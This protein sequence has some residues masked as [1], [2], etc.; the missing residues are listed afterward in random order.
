MT[1]TEKVRLK[2]LDDKADYSLWKIRLEAV[3]SVKGCESAL[4]SDGPPEGVLTDQF[5]QH[6]K[7]A[8]GIIVT[9]LNDSALR[10]VRSVIGKPN[11]MLEKLNA[12]FDSRTTSS[13]ITRMVE[14][15]S[16][17]YRGVRSDISKHIDKMAS[18]LE[19]LRAMNAII[20]DPLAVGILLAS[21]D[22]EELGP[23]VAAI[24]TLS[25]ESVKWDGVAERLIEESRSIR[26]SGHVQA[27]VA[28]SHRPRENCDYCHRPG[29]P[30]SRCWIN[31]DN[32]NNRLKALKNAGNKSHEKTDK[33]GSGKKSRRG[34]EVAAMARTSNARRSS[35]SMMIDSGTSSHITPFEH[36]VSNLEECDVTITLGDD[37]TVPSVTQGTRRVQWQGEDGP[38]N[39]N[40]SNTLVAPDVSLSLLSVPALVEKGLA[41]LFVPT[42]AFIININDGNTIIGTASQGTDKLFYISDHADAYPD[43]QDDGVETVRTFMAV[44]EPYVPAQVPKSSSSSDEAERAA[45]SDVDV[46]SHGGESE[47]TTLSD[48]DVQ[49]DTPTVTFGTSNNETTS[50]TNVSLDKN[51]ARPDSH[52]TASVVATWHR[53][54]GHGLSKTA[55]AN[56]VRAG[57]LPTKVETAAP[58][59]DPCVKGK[60]RESFKGSLTKRTTVGHLH[61]DTKGKIPKTSVN[62]Y[63]HFVTVVDEYSRFVFTHPI[64]SKGEASGVVL[65]YVRWFE[66]QSG[67]PV[68]SFHTDNGREYT[69]AI[70]ALTNMGVDTSTTTAYTAAS[71]GLAER[72]HGVLMS[73]ARAVLLQAK[74][75]Q[76]YWDYA[77][78]HVTTSK[79][80]LPHSTTKE[81]PYVRLLGQQSPDLHH[82]RPFGC[83]ILYRP[84]MDRLPTFSPRL[85]EGICL[86][87]DGGGVYRVLSMKGIV[88]TKHVR[89]LENDFPGLRSLLKNK[90]RSDQEEE[91]QTSEVDISLSDSATEDDGDGSPLDDPADPITYVPART[92]TFGNTDDEDSDSSK[93]KENSS[94]EADDVPDDDEYH[95]DGDD[96]DDE[97]DEDLPSR[98]TVRNLRNIPRVQYTYTA[99]PSCISTSDEP[100]VSEALKSPE[101]SEW[102][103]AITEEFMNLLKLKTWSEESHP[104]GAKAIPSGIVLKLK[105]DADGKPCRFKARLVA[106]G[107]LQD[108]M[109]DFGEL[110]APVACIEVVRILLAVAY[111]KGWEVHHVDIKG[112]FLYA[113]LKETRPTYIRLPKLKFIP[114]ANGLIVRLHKSLYG[115]RQAPKL[116][117]Q[118]LA[119]TLLKIN[120][121]RSRSTDCLFIGPDP[122]RPVYLLVYVDDIMVVGDARNVQTV[123]ALLASMFTTTDLGLCTHFLGIKLERRPFGLFLTQRPYIEKIINLAGMQNASA[124]DAPLPL[125]HPLYQVMEKRSESERTAIEHVPYRQV[126]GSLLFLST[127]TRPDLATSVSMLGKFQAEPT[128]RHWKMMKSVVRYLIGTKD[129][130]LLFPHGQSHPRLISW[131]DAD[132]A[133]DLTR[134]RSRSGYVLKIGTAPVVW[135][136]RLQENTAMSTSESEFNSLSAAVREIVWVRAVLKDLDTLQSGP[137]VLYQDNLGAICWTS[138]IQGLRNVKHVGMRYHFVREEV[139]KKTVT[140]QYCESA[141]NHADSLTKVLIGADFLTHRTYLGCTH[142]A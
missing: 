5:E 33:D 1:D 44:T 9:A 101:R 8:S 16:L 65:R 79:N 81:I 132:W 121:R 61:A 95:D 35:D 66:R 17:R 69:K 100:S 32:P 91:A 136:S 56:Q 78:A 21:I 38:V 113:R 135:A 96:G 75:P 51:T 52:K 70:S 87:H 76:S 108:D 88:R 98:H 92:S 82:V 31:P 63:S 116:W 110:Y 111:A 129:F 123:K 139:E 22:V 10:V 125:S 102:I 49:P 137:T 36:K 25:E 41:V 4:T 127:R 58:D 128:I 20:D 62:G 74:L 80:M 13:K 126:L 64:K 45:A 117:Y 34:S 134:R 72:Y 26:T 3:C 90:Y 39:V 124:A 23:V 67:S 99:V 106:R 54:L 18:L 97:D 122:E 24:K 50:T 60:F 112:A 104:P 77:I 83:R 40:L 48:V 71:N 114:H 30:A 89:V 107:N 12:R 131:S 46:S 130:G 141:K 103:A 11:Q 73:D 6:K 28:K 53:R 68:R 93:R 19:Q 15:V 7:T 94:S 86:G 43:D 118:L 84:V 2:V 109:F 133:R 120:F 29:H 57:V 142:L 115:L 42:R 27:T 138:E 55:I 14:L 47:S 105:R 140:V 119:Q 85:Q 59:C 37:S